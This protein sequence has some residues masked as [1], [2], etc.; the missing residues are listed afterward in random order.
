MANNKKIKKYIIILLYTKTFSSSS[1]YLHDV[2]SDVSMLLGRLYQ[3]DATLI[4]YLLA[5]FFSTKGLRDCSDMLLGSCTSPLRT[6]VEVTKVLSVLIEKVQKHAQNGSDEDSC[7]SDSDDI[8]GE[9]NAHEYVVGM[10]VRVDSRTWPGI[11]KH[12]GVGN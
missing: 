3:Y 1:I 12:G 6:H 8:R 4:L 11:N 7:C 2:S 5:F 9:T 10:T